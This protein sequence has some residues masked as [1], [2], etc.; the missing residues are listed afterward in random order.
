MQYE[1]KNQDKK[2]IHW[3]DGNAPYLRSGNFFHL[4]RNNEIH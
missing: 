3:S 2:N 4:R 1:N